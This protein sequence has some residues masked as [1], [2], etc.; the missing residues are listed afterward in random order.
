MFRYPRR[1]FL[2]LLCQLLYENIRNPDKLLM[3]IAMFS[4]L[5]FVFFLDSFQQTDSR[6]GKLFCYVHITKWMIRKIFF[7]VLLTSYF[8]KSYLTLRCRRYQT[9]Y[10][11]TVS[12]ATLLF[13][14]VFIQGQLIKIQCYM[15]LV[16]TSNNRFSS[17]NSIHP[18]VLFQIDRIYRIPGDFH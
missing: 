9:K 7:R 5:V 6:H 17:E 13:C 3:W 14:P 8:F 16:K 15:L 18:L 10:R 2:I 1:Q 11:C 12:S 4:Y